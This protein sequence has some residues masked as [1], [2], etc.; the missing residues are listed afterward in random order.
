VRYVTRPLSIEARMRIKNVRREGSQF[1]ASWKS[2]LDLLD[3]ELW[4]LGVRSDFVLQVDVEE[5][6]LR[7]DGELRAN[8]RPASPAV[9]ISVDRRGKPSLLFAC[10][11]FPHWQENVRAIALGLEA[12][13][14]V[15]RYGITQANEQ[16]T[17]FG[18]LPPGVPMPA[19]AMT[20]DEAAKLLADE[21]LWAGP[22]IGD[23]LAVQS[24]YRRAVKMNHPDT[25]GDPETF[26]RLTEARD[27]LIGAAS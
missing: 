14:K 13:R 25:G 7:L 10:G 1:S 17:G 22:L 26:R 15:E 24:A 16:Y 20:V 19:A 12:L 6:D 4:A 21:A 11:K 5:K 23:Q 27:L 2:T 8:A 3:R 18:A 9:A